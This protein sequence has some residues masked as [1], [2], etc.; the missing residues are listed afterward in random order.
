MR[1]A[2]FD[3]RSESR[4]RSGKPPSLASRPVGAPQKHVGALLKIDFRFAH[5]CREPVMLVQADASA[6]RQV[7]AH[8]DE[9]SAPAVIVDVEV[10]LHH[11]PVP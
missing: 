11:P 3:R 4:V 7:E 6:N 9:H 1:R 10:V 5:A 8:A 2:T